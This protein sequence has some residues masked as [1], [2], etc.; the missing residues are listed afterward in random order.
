MTA[1][2][3]AT[4]KT[5]LAVAVLSVIFS[6]LPVPL[7]LMVRASALP[8]CTMLTAVAAVPLVP[9]TVSPTTPFPV[10]LTVADPVKVLS[11]PKV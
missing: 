5:S 6:K 2:P 3:S 11:P 7:L 8:D 10:G 1:P 9:L 4:V